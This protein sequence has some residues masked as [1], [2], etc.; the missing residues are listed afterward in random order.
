MGGKEKRVRDW[1]EEGEG[2]N[3]TEKGEGLS[4]TCKDVLHNSTSLNLN[5]ISGFSTLPV[6]ACTT[7]FHKVSAIAKHPKKLLEKQIETRNK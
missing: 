1:Q 2:G 7:L 6:F 4:S 5:R 3:S